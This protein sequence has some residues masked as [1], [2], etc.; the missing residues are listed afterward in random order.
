ME[1]SFINIRWLWMPMVGG[2]T[3]LALPGNSTIGGILG[4]VVGHFSAG[5]VSHNRFLA[6][7]ARGV[8]Q[9]GQHA[10]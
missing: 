1:N 4:D 7:G 9:A 5:F 10:G 2:S 3:M 6:V 8:T